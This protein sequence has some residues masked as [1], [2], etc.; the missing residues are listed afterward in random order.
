MKI[1][2]SY[3]RAFFKV[4]FTLILITSSYYLFAPPSTPGGGSPPACW[5]PP[6]I[7]IDGGI[8]VLIIAGAALGLKKTHDSYKTGK[9]VEE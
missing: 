3:M 4:F 7:P 2:T 1:M 9:K 5:P 8:S 6:C